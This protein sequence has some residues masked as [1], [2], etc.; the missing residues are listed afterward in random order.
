M[1]MAGIQFLIFFGLMALGFPVA[2]SLMGAGL[3]TAFYLGGFNA[4]YVAYTSLWGQLNTDVYIAIPLFVLMAAFLQYSGVATDI[5]DTLYA[6][7]YRLR[8]SLAVCTIISCAIIAA[9]TGLGGTGTVLMAIIAYP[10]MRKYGY[11]ESLAMGCIPAAGAL[12]PIIPP[13][14]LMIILGGLTGVSVGKLFTGGFGVGILIT[15]LMCLYVIIACYLK[16]SLA[17]SI[18]LD[19]KITM[20]QKLG[21]L[22]RLIFP[23]TLILAVLGTIY[24]GVATPTEAA[25]IG[26]VGT[27]VITIAR[28]KLGWQELKTSLVLS[29]KV[30]CMVLWLLVGGALFSSVLIGMGASEWVKTAVMTWGLSNTQVIWVVIGLSFILG[31]L[32]DAV[33]VIMILLPLFMPLLM[34]ME[35]DMVWFLVFFTVFLCIGYVTPP[36]G[37]NLFYLKGILKDVPLWKIYKSVIPYVL[38]MTL[39]AVLSGIFPPIITWLVGFMK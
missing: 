3:I 25:T 20:R 38:I 29:L 34:A 31:M 22:Y 35:I 16:P 14:I 24:A 6:L 39:G 23:L 17:P 4:L 8:G 33:A 32:M 15:F 21:M 10:Q 36:Y 37:M 19:S 1:W 28:R 12:G 26:V 7:M 18:T 11:D 2:F 13:S 27:L 5:Y 9:I 30:S